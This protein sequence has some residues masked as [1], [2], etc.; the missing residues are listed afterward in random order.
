MHE[1]DVRGSMHENNMIM[2][3]V[4]ASHGVFFELHLYAAFLAISM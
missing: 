1:F 2:P 4:Y 3:I